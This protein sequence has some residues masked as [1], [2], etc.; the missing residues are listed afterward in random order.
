MS[1]LYNAVPRNQQPLRHTFDLEQF[2]SYFHF[3]ATIA[4]VIFSVKFQVF[5]V[6]RVSKR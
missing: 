3:S 5:S 6:E 1:Q 2:G 4:M